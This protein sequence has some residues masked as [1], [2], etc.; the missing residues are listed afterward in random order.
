MQNT[1]QINTNLDVNE[2]HKLNIPFKAS[3]GTGISELGFG[4]VILFS[5]SNQKNSQKLIFTI[6]QLLLLMPCDD[7]IFLFVT[8][9]FN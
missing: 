3:A 4:K 9:K 6:F 1:D 8:Q 7:N 2:L 5:I